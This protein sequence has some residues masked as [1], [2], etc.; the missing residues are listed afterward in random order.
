MSSLV[1][2]VSNY[3]TRISGCLFLLISCAHFIMIIR[4]DFLSYVA[5]TKALLPSWEK[6]ISQ[7]KGKPIIINT[8]SVAGKIGPPVRTAYAGSKHAIMGWFNAFRIEQILAGFPIQVLNIV[9]G[10]TRTDVAR[11]AVAESKDAKCKTVDSNIEQGLEVDFVVERVVAAAYAGHEEI[12]LAQKKELLVLYLN[13][14]VPE[15]ANRLFMK[16]MAKQYAVQNE[17]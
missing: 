12:W 11:N 15:V 13:Q 10:S 7:G 17:N 9:L 3:C 6:Q 8:S 1:L 4:S 14:Y 16:S 5:L 2:A